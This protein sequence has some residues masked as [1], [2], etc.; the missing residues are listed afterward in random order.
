MDNGGKTDADLRYGCS[1]YRPSCLQC[2]NNIIGAVTFIS[3]ANFM[4][5]FAN[6]LLG[7][8]MSTVERRFDLSSSESSWMASGY[9]FGAVPTLILISVFGTR[10]G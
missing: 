3:I 5:N 6:G 9:E 8:V 2:L 10:F 7:V 1:A 4:L